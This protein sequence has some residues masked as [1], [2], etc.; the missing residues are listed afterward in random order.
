MATSAKK[1]AKGATARNGKTTAKRL[2]KAEREAKKVQDL[3]DKQVKIEGQQT[4]DQTAQLV[5]GDPDARGARSAPSAGS[6]GGKFA[7]IDAPK[8]KRTA[9]DMSD[10]ESGLASKFH[11]RMDEQLK[12]ATE[13][14]PHTQARIAA[15]QN[16]DLVSEEDRRRAI[17]SKE[18]GVNV[19]PRDANEAD[20]PVEA[21]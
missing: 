14:G 6:S 11:A 7:T 3:K 10:K 19:F 12:P 5:T 13:I 2:T 4:A 18:L 20:A 16:P 15:E 9:H 1:A 21:A 8:I 17:A